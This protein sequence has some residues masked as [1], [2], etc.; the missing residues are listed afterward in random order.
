MMLRAAAFATT[1]LLPGTYT[2]GEQA[3][4]AA[5]AGKPVPTLTGIRVTAQGNGFRGQGVDAHGTAVGA[6]AVWR[7]TQRDHID[8]VSTAGCT[9]DFSPVADG[10]TMTDP[11]GCS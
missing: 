9:R 1:A 5:E 11:A 2:D 8:S 4:F 3:Y 6:D 7:V 10:L